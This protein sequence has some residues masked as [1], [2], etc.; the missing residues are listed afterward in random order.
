MG[1]E[2]ELVVGELLHSSWKGKKC[3]PHR[4]AV[5]QVESCEFHYAFM[6]QNVYFLAHDFTEVIK[7]CASP[8]QNN[9]QNTAG[10]KLGYN[11]FCEGI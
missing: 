2:G 8:F 11:L 4:A 7:S 9:L 1:K 6:N 5:E 10:L 3:R